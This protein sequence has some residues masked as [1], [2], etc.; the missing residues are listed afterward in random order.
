MLQVLQAT[1]LI[2]V[3]SLFNKSTQK[4]IR[5]QGLLIVVTKFQAQ[6]TARKLFLIFFTT[7]ALSPSCWNQ[8]FSFVSHP[9]EQ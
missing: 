4:I 8:H 6:R 7:W 9:A 1:W 2:A 5:A 3:K